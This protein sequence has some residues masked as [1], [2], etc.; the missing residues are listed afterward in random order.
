LEV[1]IYMIFSSISKEIELKNF[2]L[3][4]NLWIIWIVL[5]FIKFIRRKNIMYLIILI[6]IIVILCV[7]LIR[8]LRIN[9]AL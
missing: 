3:L 5:Y 9:L 7:V 8:N 4:S 2:I 6:P 1:V